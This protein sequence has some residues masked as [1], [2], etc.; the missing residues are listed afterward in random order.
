MRVPPGDGEL[1]FHY[2]ALSFVAPEMVRFSVKTQGPIATESMQESKDSPLYEST[3]P[4]YT[5][6]VMA[7]NNAGVWNESGAAFELALLPHFYET[8][9]F[10]VTATLGIA[11]TAAVITPPIALCRVGGRYWRRK[12]TRD[13]TIE[14]QDQR[15]RPGARVAAS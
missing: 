13:E 1:L 4:A 2:I 15:P 6:R 8:M 14:T 11:S 10:Y 3:A 9:W 7:C 5:F 12:V